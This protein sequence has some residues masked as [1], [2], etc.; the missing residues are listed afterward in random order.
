MGLFYRLFWLFALT[1]FVVR[2]W[3]RESDALKVLIGGVL[4]IA[5]VVLLAPEGS[6]LSSG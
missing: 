5:L 4:L 1:P 2:E 3:V 6:V